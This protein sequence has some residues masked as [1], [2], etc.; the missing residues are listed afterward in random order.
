MPETSFSVVSFSLWKGTNVIIQNL[1]NNQ[2]ENL[3][4]WEQS[5]WDWVPTCRGVKTKREKWWFK[6]SS[7]NEWTLLGEHSTDNLSGE[8][9]TAFRKWTISLW[10][11]LWT[12]WRSHNIRTITEASASKMCRHNVLR[13]R[14]WYQKNRVRLQ[15]T[16]KQPLIKLLSQ[17]Q[18]KLAM[19]CSQSHNCVCVR[20]QTVTGTNAAKWKYPAI[21]DVGWK[22]I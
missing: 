6:I 20:N 2:A 17:N 9:R 11:T 8:I 10:F 3:E 5:D 15:L 12:G 14:M 19:T 16:W 21:K 7:W 13:L 1:S 22:H 4:C 18:W